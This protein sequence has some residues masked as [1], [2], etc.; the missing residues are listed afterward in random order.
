MRDPKTF[1]VTLYL[2]LL[3]RYLDVVTTYLCF[4][5]NPAAFEANPFM[6]P[7]LSNP[8]LLFVVQTLGGLLVWAI[9]VVAGARSRSPR[10]GRLLPWVAVALSYPP[11]VNNLLVLMGFSDILGFLYG[12]PYG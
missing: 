9:L 7:L 12:V 8:P 11:V 6:A 4:A 3:G 1:L 10:C 5:A 2:T